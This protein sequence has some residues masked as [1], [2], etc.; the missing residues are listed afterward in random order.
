MYVSKTLVFGTETMGKKIPEE[1]LLDLQKRF[2]AKNAMDAENQCHQIIN[3]A[4][5]EGEW[6]GIL[7]QLINTKANIFDEGEGCNGSKSVL[8]N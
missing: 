3:H 4:K 1:R 2:V 5:E 7:F 6:Q 8:W